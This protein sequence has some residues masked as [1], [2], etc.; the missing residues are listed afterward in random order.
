MLNS[1]GMVWDSHDL[2]WR[3]KYQ[4]LVIYKD[5]YGD[6]NV[7]S[8]HKD[9]KLSTWVKCQRRQHKLYVDKRSS[10]MTPERIADLEAIGF[11]W[12]I[13]H[14]VSKNATFPIQPLGKQTEP[15]KDTVTLQNVPRRHV[16][17]VP[18]SA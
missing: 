18:P 9:K 3:E 11:S 1:L 12:E 17:M 6:C 16:R 8:N 7:P 13:R 5:K 15:A 2:N 14:V 4:M 10:S